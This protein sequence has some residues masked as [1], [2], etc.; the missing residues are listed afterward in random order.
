M[1][2]PRCKKTRLHPISTV[3]IDSRKRWNY[4]HR[5]RSC[6]LCNHR[7]NTVEVTRDFWFRKLERDELRTLPTDAG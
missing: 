1:L 4:V 7:F 5:R 3:V 2:C 6:P